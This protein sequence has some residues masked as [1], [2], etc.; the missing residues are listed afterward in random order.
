MTNRLFPIAALTK[1]TR[2]KAESGY[3]LRVRWSLGETSELPRVEDSFVVTIHELRGDRYMGADGSFG[4]KGEIRTITA[5]PMLCAMIDPPRESV[6]Y[7]ADPSRVWDVATRPE[8]VGDCEAEV[9]GEVKGGFF[10]RHLLAETPPSRVQRRVERLIEDRVASARRA[11]L[12]HSGIQAFAGGEA[13][14]LRA[15]RELAEIFVRR[16]PRP[17]FLRR[18]LQR[19]HERLLDAT[20]KFARGD[21]SPAGGLFA[22]AGE[23]LAKPWQRVMLASELLSDD[24]LVD[25]LEGITTPPRQ[26]RQQVS[27][28]MLQGGKMIDFW[29]S[30]RRPSKQCADDE[31]RGVQY[32]AAE[33]IGTGF[34]VG[35]FGDETLRKWIEGLREWDSILMIEVKHVRAI[36]ASDPED[37]ARSDTFIDDDR[38]EFATASFSLRVKDIKSA[39]ASGSSLPPPAPLRASISHDFFQTNAGSH[40]DVQLGYTTGESHVEF[41]VTPGKSRDPGTLNEM[42]TGFNIYGM[43]EEPAT[44]Q[45]FDDPSSRPGDLRPWLISRKYS[46]ERD[47]KGAFPSGAGVHPALVKALEDPPWQP[48]LSRADEITDEND[49]P[50]EIDENGKP[51]GATLPNVFRKDDAAGV[52]QTY[53]S[54]D[55]RNG[56]DS[57]LAAAQRR[58]V[59]WDTQGVIK[60]E[61]TPRYKRDGTLSD[62]RPQRYRFWVTATDAFE[63]ESEPIAVATHDADAG[64][65]ESVLFEPR[66]RASLLPPP[67]GPGRRTLQWTPAADDR[68]T[69][70]VRWE[71]PYMNEL[72]RRDASAPARA[73]KQDLLGAVKLLRRRLRRKVDDGASSTRGAFTDAFAANDVFATPQWTLALD[74]LLSEGWQEFKAADHVLPQPGGGDDWQHSFD[75]EHPDRGFEYMALIGM[76]VRPDRAAFWRPDVLVRGPNSGRRAFVAVKNGKEWTAVPGRV[77]ETPRTSAAVPTE[78]WVKGGEA[79]AG[80]LPVPN[81]AEPRGVTLTPVAPPHRPEPVRP[82]PRV[83]RDLVLLRLLTRAVAK[84]SPEV[85]LD[86]EEPLTLGQAAMLAAA[87]ERTAGLVDPLHNAAL[88]DTRKILA[89]E[90]RKDAKEDGRAYRRNMTIGFRGVIELRW[91]YQPWSVVAPRRDESEAEKVRVFSVRVPRDIARA[92]R[93]A[94]LSAEGR[95][96]GGWYELNGVDVNHPVVEAL[97]TFHQPAL[98]RIEPSSGGPVLDAGLEEI[99]TV[100]PRVRL[101]V[102]VDD[103]GLP[104]AATISVF[105][106]Q[107]VCDRAIDAER[108]E[109]EDSFFLPIGGGQS[110][111]FGW[112]LQTIS[113]QGV[114]SGHRRERRPFHV[115]YEVGTIEPEIPVGFTTNLPARSEAAYAAD[116]QVHA[117]WL[118]TDIAQGSAHLAQHNARVVVGWNAYLV[119]DGETVGIEI[120][121]EE[122]LVEHES[123]PQA[124]ASKDTAVWE[125]AREINQMTDEALLEPAWVRTLRSSWLLGRVVEVPGDAGEPSSVVIP[126][127]IER[128]LPGS[129]GMKLVDG[130]PAF[131]DYFRRA[132]D[133]HAAMDGNWE[134]RYRI[135]AW[136]DLLAGAA[137]DV[138]P[139]SRILRGSSTPWSEWILPEP[140]EAALGAPLLQYKPHG[141]D[142]PAVRFSITA[143]G[144]RFFGLVAPKDG[145]FYRVVIKRR[146]AFFLP[147]TEHAIDEPG[148]REVGTSL[149][150][151]PDGTSVEVEDLRIDR[152][153][154]DRPVTLNYQISANQLIITPSGRERLVR[155]LAK[156]DFS[157]TIPRPP[158]PEGKEVMAVVLMEIR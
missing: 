109:V 102:A 96:S 125:A 22:F 60:L 108:G 74:S 32:P 80:A 7:P 149:V 98:V 19:E 85:W 34:S 63:Q 10:V 143:A 77:S 6:P 111:V 95:L 24:S 36:A 75:L 25:A 67:A 64:E 83:V 76:R 110:E 151:P 105:L 99:T 88:R 14:D 84:S 16:A 156:Q 46:Y 158:N 12:A 101:R 103:G 122:R 115:S 154:I 126:A 153:E 40:E 17:L 141:S 50:T 8:Q 127:D 148:W 58:F 70:T 82:L 128:P 107:P 136:L 52:L 59:G 20:R 43:W 65:A 39:L 157:V 131:I 117:P 121:R 119:E 87:L 41:V 81:L 38:R 123:G 51:K 93:H 4:P 1:K 23:G 9:V 130:R 133:K 26:A 37:A 21:H 33:L 135:R 53:S 116:P 144:N 129:R 92:R 134:Y 54:I 138:D 13:D 68:S 28:R 29:C 71:T 142:T 66:H 48:V 91:R 45:F 152:A 55:L 18:A 114:I 86:T 112:W 49:E 47:L 155:V 140:G 44:K 147:S 100:G 27:L 2:D 113:A 62:G 150:V 57:G 42:V 31:A 35:E 72:G 73:D 120:E 118:P 69:I 5:A 124:L 137:P 3:E 97:V 139:G 90:L 104:T 146:L 106:A 78:G 145:W 94:A 89:R 61:W 15:S 79:R 11:I 56:M 132:D 30:P